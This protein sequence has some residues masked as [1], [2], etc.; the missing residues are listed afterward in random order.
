LHVRISDHPLVVAALA[1]HP[2]PG[3]V[4]VLGDHREL[5][6]GLA[7]LADGLAAGLLGVPSR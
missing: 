1:A 2:H 4:A 5:A 7:L 6:E 3:L